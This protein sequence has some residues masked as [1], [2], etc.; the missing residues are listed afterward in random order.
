[1]PFSIQQ[2]RVSEIRRQLRTAKPWALSARRRPA[3]SGMP[4]A[5]PLALLCGL[6]AFTLSLPCLRRDDDLGCL[7]V[8]FL[9]K[10]T[11]ISLSI[12]VG[13]ALHTEEIV[14]FHSLAIMKFK[15]GPLRL[16]EGMA[17]TLKAI[18]LPRKAFGIGQQNILVTS[19]RCQSADAS[20]IAL[21]KP[22]WQQLPVELLHIIF[23]FLVLDTIALRC[24]SYVCRQWRSQAQ[25]C[26]FARIT[27]NVVSVLA[28]TEKRRASSLV[29]FFT[30]VDNHVLAAGVTILCLGSKVNDAHGKLSMHLDTFATLICALPRLRHVQLLWLNLSA[31]GQVVP[32]VVNEHLRPLES[33]TLYRSTAPEGTLSKLLDIRDVKGALCLDVGEH[34]QLDAAD[35]TRCLKV[36]HLVFN[37][38]LDR[39]PVC[40]DDSTKSTVEELTVVCDE[41]TT[42]EHYAPLNRFL[43]KYGSRLEYLNLD[44]THKSMRQHLWWDHMDSWDIFRLSD[45][46]PSLQTLRLSMRSTIMQNGDSSDA[47][48]QVHL[49]NSEIRL[50]PLIVG[51]APKSLT[52]LMFDIPVNHLMLA[53]RFNPQ[54]FRHLIFHRDGW[55][56]LKDGSRMHELDALR[57]VEFRIAEEQDASVPPRLRPSEASFALIRKQIVENLR[58]LIARNILYLA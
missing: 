51:S 53:P 13:I 5:T 49:F 43:R 19:R 14:T 3:F 20:G 9:A 12:L 27:H 15:V 28:K 58:E 11:A 17:K 37:G 56:L 44:I 42:H 7:A 33:F 39:F 35:V 34:L 10:F 30:A 21:G 48:T 54:D 52:R 25:R 32:S 45:V 55:G 18:L 36:R 2:A 50:L 24:S 46:C 4:L 16:E 6:A 40:E 23:Q 29:G 22:G 47:N 41:G 57:S 26:L 38:P 1:M 8:H 31:W